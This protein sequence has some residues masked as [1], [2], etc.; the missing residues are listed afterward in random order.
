MKRN[1]DNDYVTR[2]FCDSQK[3]KFVSKEVCELKDNSLKDSIISIIEKIDTFENNH[4]VHM[5]ADIAKMREELL[6]IKWKVAII[7]SGST[8]LIVIVL[9]YIMNIMFVG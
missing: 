5:Q 8:F 9:P 7:S 1:S 3:S 6:G 4:F 2:E